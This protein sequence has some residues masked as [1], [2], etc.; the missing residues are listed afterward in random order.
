MIFRFQYQDE[1]GDWEDLGE[2]EG[3]GGTSVQDAVTQLQGKRGA[4]LPG[5]QYRYRP[6]DSPEG[7]WGTFLLIAAAT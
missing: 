2:A 3:S 4:N 7:E 6:L 1:G 5:G